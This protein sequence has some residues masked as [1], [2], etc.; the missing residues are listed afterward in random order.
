MAFKLVGDQYSKIRQARKRRVD[1]LL[2][3]Q[4]PES[5]VLKMRDGRFACTVCSSRPVFDTLMVLSV[6]RKGKKHIKAVLANMKRSL[7]E[8]QP[9]KAEQPLLAQTQAALDHA[10]FS[11]QSSSL[12]SSFEKEGDIKEGTDTSKRHGPAHDT[13][14]SAVP[15]KKQ[16]MLQ[17][18]DKA[19]EVESDKVVTSSNINSD[20]NRLRSSGWLPLS[21]GTWIKDPQVEFDSS[22]DDETSDEGKT[23]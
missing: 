7:E 11:S 15:K 4:I 5:E 23:E 8:S 14:D 6:H 19:C 12:S 17:S 22:S 13:S 20:Y 10:L 16:K 2:A 18:Q 21:D 9:G 1:H 3:G